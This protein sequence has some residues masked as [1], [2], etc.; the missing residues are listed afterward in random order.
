MR[1]SVRTQVDG[2]EIGFM[3]KQKVYSV[4]AFLLVSGA[5]YRFPASTSSSTFGFPR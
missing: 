5:S 4:S 3:E 1:A 2:L